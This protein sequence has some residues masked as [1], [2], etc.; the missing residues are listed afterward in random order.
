MMNTAAELTKKVA[1]LYEEIVTNTVRFQAL[2]KRTDEV[3]SEV[4]V[5]VTR[6]Q[7][8]AEAMHHQHVQERAEILARI[9]SLHARLNVLSEQ[10]LHSVVRDVIREELRLKGNANG[11][12][13][14]GTVPP[15]AI[16]LSQASGA[17]MNVAP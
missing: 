10:A 2:E 11:D 17:A 6:L 3:L 8:K 5:L 15:V 7:D 12:M 1:S 9:D 14:A 13:S 16:A 4:K